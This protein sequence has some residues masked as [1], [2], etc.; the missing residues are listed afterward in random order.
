MCLKVY[1]P[2]HGIVV[3]PHFLAQWGERHPNISRIN[4]LI[5]YLHRADTKFA[6]IQMIGDTPNESLPR[7]PIPF[8]VHTEPQIEC[9]YS[10][11]RTIIMTSLLYRSR[12]YLTHTR[13]LQL[14][15]NQ[16]RL[17]TEYGCCI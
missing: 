13:L 14:Y 6:L 9:L 15:N 5:L 4:L 1:G 11:H 8:K 2:R 7:T 12:S 3:I 10:Y 17:I 16:I